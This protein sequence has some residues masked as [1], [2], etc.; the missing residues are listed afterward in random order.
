MPKRKVRR[1]GSGYLT[2]AESREAARLQAHVK[3]ELDLFYALSDLE[4]AIYRD[5]LL[6]QTVDLLAKG[7]EL[8]NKYEQRKR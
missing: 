3:L 8:L 5:F 1:V 4:R 6:L 2:P 7:N